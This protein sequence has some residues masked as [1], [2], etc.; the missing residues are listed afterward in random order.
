MRA[1]GIRELDT[2]FRVGCD[3]PGCCTPHDPTRDRSWLH[4]TCHVGAPPWA[5][6]VRGVLV[7]ECSL[8]SKRIIAI[9]PAVEGVEVDLAGV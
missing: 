9:R 1:F 6:Y 8:C 3:V 2:A 4:A 5:Y 7:L